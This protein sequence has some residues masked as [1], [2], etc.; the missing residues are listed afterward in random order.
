MSRLTDLMEAFQE[1]YVRGVAAAAG[2]V[3]SGRP[4]ID[5]GIDIIL[6]HRSD[7]HKGGDGVARLEIQLKATA[8]SVGRGGTH[9]SARVKKARYDYF[10]SPNPDVKK[11]LV[12]MHLPAHQHEWVN[13]GVDAL[14]LRHRAYWVDLEG[15]P[16]IAGSTTTV[17]APIANRFD[18]VALCGI[19]ERIGQ[20]GRP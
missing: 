3:I 6:T 2:C 10:R 12:I 5:E 11:I 13:L 9:V 8:T 19:M 1:S 16:P 7:K 4:E 14:H 20:G 15:M 18:D 17:K